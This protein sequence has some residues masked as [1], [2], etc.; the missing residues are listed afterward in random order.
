MT[1]PQTNNATSE[2]LNF[3]KHYS[4]LQLSVSSIESEDNLLHEVQKTRIRISHPWELAAGEDEH[5]LPRKGCN[6]I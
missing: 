5:I 1:F 3:L 6:E 2:H 4:L